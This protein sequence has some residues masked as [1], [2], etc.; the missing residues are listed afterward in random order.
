MNAAAAARKEPFLGMDFWLLAFAM[1][2]TAFGLIMVLS[3][4]GIMA[5]RYYGDKYHFFFKQVLFSGLGAAAMTLFAVTSLERI[6]KL[7]YVFLMASVG[8]LVLALASPLGIQV[9]GARRWLRL[10]SL[11]LQPMEFAKVALVFYLAWFFSQK[12]ELVK[13]FSVGV[14]PPFAV[15]GLLCAMVLAQP[16]FGGAAV[17]AMLLFLMC[18]AGGTRFIYLFTSICMAVGAAAL[19]IVHSPYR[20]R[21]L[22][23]FLD[24]FQDAH[25]SG[26]QLVQSLYALGTGRLWGVGL[27]AGTQKLFFLPEAH[28][29]FIIAVVGEE[30]G[31]VGVSMVFLLMGLLIWRAFAVAISLPE[32]RDRLTAYGMALVLALGAVLNMAVV[33]GT[34]PPKGV[35]MPFLS[36][37]GSSL[38]ASF[39]CVGVLL[40]LSRRR[41]APAISRGN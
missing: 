29:D 2:L 9:N 12:R 20:S 19:L 23:A 30:L 3:A 41:T 4:S 39:L 26:Y 7:K 33:L 21:R 40:N 37:G 8:L 32:L 6:Y 17:I 34:A 35:P 13:T 16:D 36:Y 18:L 22:L 38:I 14:I 25:D 15:T 1:L 31:F 5:E 11:T 24:P 27:G 28:N 10:G